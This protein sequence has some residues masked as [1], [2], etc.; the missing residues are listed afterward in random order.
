MTDKDS[1]KLFGF[2]DAA[3]P[4]EVLQIIFSYLGIFMDLFAYIF[5]CDVEAFLLSLK[6]FVSWCLFF[7]VPLPYKSS[8]IFSSSNSKYKI[9]NHLILFPQ[10]KYNIFNFVIRPYSG[11]ILCH[12]GCV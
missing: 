4:K 2:G 3:L 6:L 1:H 11:V 7:Y 12:F 5:V 9:I 10:T 8:I